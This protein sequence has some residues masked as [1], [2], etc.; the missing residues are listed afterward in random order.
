MAG[1]TISLGGLPIT[2]PTEAITQASILLWGAAGTG[3]STLA[4]TAPGDILLI[5]FDQ[6]GAQGVQPVVNNAGKECNIY[7]VRFNAE[8]DNVV[9]KFKTANP[10]NIET[11]LKDNPNIKT[12]VFDSLTSFSEKALAFGVTRAKAT[13][14]GRNAT[15]EDPGYSGYGHKRT[16]VE[17]CVRNIA[18]SCAKYDVNCIFIAH[19]GPPN[20]NNDGVVVERTL[21][22]GSSLNITIPKDIGEI[23]Y[24]ADTGKERRL[25]IRNSGPIKPMRS[26]IFIT[27]NIQHF[28]LNF[29][30]DKWQG[31]GI[32]DWIE[33]W[34]ANDFKKINPPKD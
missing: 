33:A 19:E 9:E 18:A 3:K 27:E 23:W 1:S 7:V 2:S 4:M 16:Y 32:A 10:V 8:S 31:T 20:V 17:Q 24:L 25:Y 11:T 15:L 26:R 5:Q 34:K 12:V 14:K 13:P 22:L 6:T 29:D 28:K 30:A 21:L